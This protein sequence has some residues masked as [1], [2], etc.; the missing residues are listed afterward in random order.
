MSEH[1]AHAHDDHDKKAPKVYA[2]ILGSLL[3]LTFITVSASYINFGSPMVNVGIAM[4]I[5]T[6]KATLVALF[7]M[8][9]L[10]DKPVNSI[11]LVSSFI[12]LGIF[13]GSCYTDWASRDAIEPANKKV[14]PKPAPATAPP[15]AAPVH[16]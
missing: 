12:F 8:H 9:L 5:A 6:I 10:H 2:L 1:I 4:T 11:I 3:I 16:H 14:L 13:L 7:F 15:V